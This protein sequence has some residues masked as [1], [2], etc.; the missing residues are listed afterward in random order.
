MKQAPRGVGYV[1]AVWVAVLTLLTGPLLLI[2]PLFIGFMQDRHDVADKLRISGEELDRV[3]TEIVWDIFTGGSFE[4]AFATGQPVLGVEERSHMRDVSQL[5]RVLVAI[6]LFALWFAAWGGRLLRTEPARLG[7]LLITGAGGVGVAVLAAG[8]FA[9]LAWDSAF[10]LFHQLLFP[11]G[12]WSF[13][14]DSTLIQLYPPAFWFEAAMVAGTLIL[15]TAA[16]LSYA[17]WRRI[18]EAQP[19]PPAPQLPD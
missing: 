7:R 4:V 1:F 13:P 17:G 16:A 12:T 2:N 8:A 14:E 15:L 18:R 6:D 10:T 5:V 11:P 3:N 19:R 9:V